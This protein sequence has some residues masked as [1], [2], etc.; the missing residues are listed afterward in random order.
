MESCRY[1]CNIYAPLLSAALNRSWRR[2]S[3]LKR[4]SP[5]A[6]FPSGFIQLAVILLC[7]CIDSSNSPIRSILSRF[8]SRV[9]CHSFLATPP[10]RIVVLHSTITP[11][12]YNYTLRT[13]S[14]TGHRREPFVMA[15]LPANAHVS[16]HPCVRAKLSQLRSQ[17]TAAR[18]VKSLINEIATIVGVE[19]LGTCLKT[20]ES[21]SVCLYSNL[22]FLCL[23]SL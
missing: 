9:C 7:H 18:E 21:G 6:T 1:L 22:S 16:T 5:R 17:S 14:G 12:R 19:A 3:F 15:S 23:H 10:A 4:D 8:T 11:Q 13:T 2:D 20:V